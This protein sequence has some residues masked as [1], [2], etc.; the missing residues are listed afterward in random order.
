MPFHKATNRQDKVAHELASVASDDAYHYE[1][2]G[3]VFKDGH[4]VWHQMICTTN[5]HRSWIYWLA[6][7][8]GSYRGCFL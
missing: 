3:T 2:T 4:F 1:P 8:Y 6:K 5:D 7:D